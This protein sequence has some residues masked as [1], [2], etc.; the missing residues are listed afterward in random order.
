MIIIPTTLST[1]INPPI[2]TFTDAVLGFTEE[3]ED[4]E[5]ELDEL[6]GTAVSTADCEVELVGVAVAEV[7]IEVKFV[8]GTIF[9][10]RRN[11]I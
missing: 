5:I 1:P 2:R 10:G 6:D 3:E 4:G 9:S 7:E 11:G 8:P